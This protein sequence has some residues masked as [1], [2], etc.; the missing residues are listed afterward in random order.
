MFWTFF[1]IIGTLLTATAVAVVLPRLVLLARTA[2]YVCRDRGIRKLN[3][4]NGIAVVCEPAPAYRSALRQYCL[5][6][7]QEGVQFVGKWSDEVICAEYDLYAYDGC[8]RAISLISVKELPQNGIGKRIA[9]PKDTAFVSPALRN[10]NGESRAVARAW[11]AQLLLSLPLV[12]FLTAAVAIESLLCELSFSHLIADGDFYFASGAA[13][14]LTGSVF[15]AAAVQA[16]AVFLVFGAKKLLAYLRERRPLRRLG[17]LR[18][19]GKARFAIGNLYYRVRNFFAS[20]LTGKVALSVKRKFRG[21]AIKVRLLFSQAAGA[22]KSTLRKNAPK[23][24]PKNAQDNAR[25]TAPKNA[26]DNAQ[27]T[28]PENADAPEKITEEDK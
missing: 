15:F 22:V 1:F 10:V 19:V 26:Q 25:E 21:A 3:T 9:L 20:L 16:V 13:S 17:Q 18:A 24:A 11:K 5:A 27:V 14:F 23:N 12:L 4:P 2:G 8:G 6:R 7:S 28:A